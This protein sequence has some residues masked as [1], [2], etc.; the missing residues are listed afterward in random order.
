MQT[1][2]EIA[3]QVLATIGTIISI[4]CAYKAIFVIVGLLKVKH[5]PAAKQQHTYGICIA[6][7]NEEK[8]IQ[9]LL[10]SILNQD[11]P[12]DKLR[13]FVVA[14]NCTDNT[15]QIVRDFAA[16]HNLTNISLY[17]HNNPDERTKG[18]ALKYLFER[19]Q[20]D[21]TIAGYEGYF[22]FDADNV[23]HPDYISRMNE[24]FDAGKKI[25]TSFRNSKNTNQNWISFGYAMHWIGTCLFE[26]RA[27]GVLDQACRIQGTGF[28]FANELVKNGWP[29]TSLT[30]DRA[31]CSDAVVQNYRISYCDDA[32]F[33]DEQPYKLKVA[34]R[35]RLRWAKGHLQSSVENCPK[36]LT[37]MFKRHKTFTTTWDCFWLNFPGAIESGI[38]R[39]LTWT[40]QMIIF[41]LIGTNF[42]NN[43]W[44]VIIFAYFMGLV[45]S[46]LGNMFR[47]LITIIWYRKRIGKLPFWKT[48]FHLLMFQLF[49]EIGRWC[50]YIAL[51][52]KVEWKPIPHDTVMDINALKENTDTPK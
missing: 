43:V 18:F 22:I 4:L 46:W 23:L 31:F 50:S 1:F 44:E 37:N 13:V 33:Y 28:L 47:G 41:A 24:A 52:K 51:F 7:R 49:Y 21:F 30:E 26:N 36:L 15:A 9:N 38:R 19:V 2:A 29:Y 3:I 10:E 40:L 20:E 25:V 5:F 39:L 8:V 32:V 17:E 45:K 42:L 6:A 34:L 16:E 48:A 35:Q 11:Y 14:D 12:Q 27:K